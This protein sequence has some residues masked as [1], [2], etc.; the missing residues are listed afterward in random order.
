FFAER[1]SQLLRQG[2]IT[3][4]VFPSAFHANQSATGIRR[5]YLER[6]TIRCCFS[7][8]NRKKLFDIHRSFK[9]AAI[10]ARKENAGSAS[11]HCGF[12]WHD[13]ERLFDSR[14]RLSYNRD[15]VKRTGGNYYTFLELRGEEDADAAKTLFSSGEMVDGF[16]GRSAVRLGVEIDMSKGAH[17]FTAAD[18]VIRDGS[19]GRDPA[20]SLRLR[21]QGFLLLHEGKTFHQFDDRWESPPRYLVAIQAIRDKAAWLVP[22]Q[23][24]RLAFR[25]I[26][27]STDERTGIFCVLPPGI[28][29]GNKAPCERQPETRPTSASLLLAAIANSFPF[30]FSLRMKVQATVNLFIL[31]GCPF[32][33]LDR[34]RQ[35]FLAHT[36]LRLSC[37]HSGFADLW[38][39]QVGKCWREPKPEYEWPVLS[40]ED[41]RWECRAAIDAVVADAYDLSRHQ[42]EHILSTFSHASYPK[43]PYLCLEAFDEL[44]EIGIDAFCQ[45]RDP[46]WDIPLNE[47]LPQP[48]LDLQIPGQNGIVQASL[49]PLFDS[50][51]AAVAQAEI[52]MSTAP[53]VTAKPAPAPA[54]SVRASGNG[55]FATI[56]ELLCSRG[57][58]TSSDAQQ[59]TGLD[60]AGVRPHLQRLVSEGLAVTEGQRRGMKYRRVDD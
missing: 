17:F 37:N 49:G 1:G 58:I 32:P 25:D 52:G 30:D 5:L 23:Y 54:L 31:N 6:M 7:F 15:F 43:A 26:A 38:A 35:I 48:V 10:A 42:Y 53:S 14:R 20:V 39:E 40:A 11:F 2:G 18:S 3:G 4:Q 12:Y 13:L 16:T 60:A 36:A 24:Y 56:T 57:V 22:A 27:R 34:L 41:T 21:S 44:R 33:S 8:E 50:T 51:A 9:F 29:C 28:L 55:A 45:K 47:N 19:D 59:V 46:Y